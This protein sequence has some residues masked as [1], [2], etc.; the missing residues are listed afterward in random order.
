MRTLRVQASISPDMASRYRAMCTRLEKFEEAGPPPEIPRDQTIKMRLKG[1]RTGV[2][3]I[4]VEQLE[5]TGLMQ[6]FSVEVFYG[7]RVGVLGA[8]GA[9][10]SHFL[11]LLAGDEVR[12]A[13]DWKLGARV[14]PGPL[15]ADAPPPRP[16]AD[17]A[18]STC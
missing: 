13:G 7:E 2:R 12:H 17:D 4:T 10:K 9:G 3:A 18:A 8:N 6:P 16:G 11:R 1:G 15:R 14:V 5:L